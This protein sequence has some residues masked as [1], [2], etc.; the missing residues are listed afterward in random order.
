MSRLVIYGTLDVR[1]F[2]F[3]HLFV[4]DVVAG[5]AMKKILVVVDMQNDFVDGALGTPEAQAI[6][7]AVVK[8]IATYPADCVWATRDTHSADYLQTQ[9][10]AHL[11]VEHCIKDRKGWQI[12]PQVAAVLSPTARIFDK[13]SFGSMDLTQALVEEDA[14]ELALSGEHI[15]VEFIG[16]CTDIC[17]VSNALLA[18]A[19]LPEVTISV[20]PSC[21]AGVTPAAHEAALATMRSCQVQ[22]A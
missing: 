6:V 17:V 20:D 18:K 13:P 16:L 9:E 21:C 7:P 3:V 12:C 4:V 15:E 1:T 11:P 22:G 10:G 14:R 2:W 19:A 5:G 8:K